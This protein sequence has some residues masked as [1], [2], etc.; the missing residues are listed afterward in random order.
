M[1]LLAFFVTVNLITLP[2]GLVINNNYP[3]NG[4]ISVGYRFTYNA[5]NGMMFKYGLNA[6]I[7]KKEEPDDN[8]LVFARKE[9]AY[10]CVICPSF[11]QIRILND[12]FF[13][14]MELSFI[15]KYFKKILKEDIKDLS[16]IYIEGVFIGFKGYG[17]SDDNKEMV[18]YHCFLDRKQNEGFPDMLAAYHK[19]DEKHYE[20]IVLSPFYEALTKKTESLKSSSDF[21]PKYS[22]D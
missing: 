10:T 5:S 18:L 6:K 7:I 15:N 16:P 20:S 9:V 13:K 22:G 4:I 1:S 19:Q 14:K 2:I 11:S 3:T 21:T 8:T 12:S 17:Y